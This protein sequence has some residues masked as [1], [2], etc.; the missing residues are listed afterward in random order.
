MSKKPITNE[1]SDRKKAEGL[2]ANY[3]ELDKTKRE[4][5]AAQKE[6][7]VELQELAEKNE[8]WFEGKTAQFEAGQLKWVAVSKVELPE[9]FD[10]KA[11]AKKYPNLVEI[12]ESESIPVSKLKVYLDDPKIG[13]VIGDMGVGIK[14][15][16]QFKV[17]V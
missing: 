4:S 5:A 2:I 16:N 3:A 15:T 11:F 12:K 17:V 6:I 14:T 10:L 8:R 9:D 13:T 1:L 7:E